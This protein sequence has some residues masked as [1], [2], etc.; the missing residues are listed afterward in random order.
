MTSAVLTGD[1]R[2]GDF[3][4]VVAVEPRC[5]FWKWWLSRDNGVRC[6]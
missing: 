1:I 5:R 2:A 4:V 6:D 3:T